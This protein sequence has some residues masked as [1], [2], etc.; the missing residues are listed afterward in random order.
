V[1]FFNKF[2]FWF[3]INLAGWEKEKER[4]RMLKRIIGENERKQPT[5]SD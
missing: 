5:G 3:K 1:S 2:I 4:N